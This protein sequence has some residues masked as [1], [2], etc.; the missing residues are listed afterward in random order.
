MEPEAKKE[1]RRILK[2]AGD[3]EPDIFITKMSGILIART[4]L[5]PFE[6]I[7]KI[8]EMLLEEPW[9][10]RYCH[11]L[12]PIQVITE[13]RIKDVEEGVEHISEKILEKDTYKI[14]VKKRDADISSQE[15]ISRIAEKIPN[16][17]SL[18]NPDKVILVEV[19]GKETGIAIIQK[20]D[21]LSVEKT[22][23]D[24]SELA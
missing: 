4:G 3:T 9:S 5:D 23:R 14:S 17:V 21:I 22:K 18:D 2:Q 6:A 1:T 10:I 15:W 16:K 7:K 19:L 24:M 11:R 20:D 12:I 13:T 8:R